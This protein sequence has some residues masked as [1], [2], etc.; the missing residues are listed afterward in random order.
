VNAVAPGPTLTGILQGGI[1]TEEHLE[2]LRRPI[3]LQRLAGPQEQAEV[4]WFLGTAASSFV[5]GTTV[6]C[7][8]GITA[9]PGIFPPPPADLSDVHH[10]L[11]M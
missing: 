11:R 8:G 10:C 6:M 7:N 3:P 4:I 2:A 9:N 1:V 5:T